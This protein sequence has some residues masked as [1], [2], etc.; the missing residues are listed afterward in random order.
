VTVVGVFALFIAQLLLS[1]VIS[2]GAY[3]ISSL[4]SQ[5]RQLDREVQALSEQIDLL[6][7]PQSLATKAESLGMVLSATAPAFVRLA[8][9]A[10]IGQGS[11]GAVGNALLGSTG[12]L[13]PNS[14]LDTMTTESA[15]VLGA[16]G[17]SAAPAGA[18]DMAPAS[19]A[20]VSTL[21]SLPSPVTR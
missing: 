21:D 12:S 4:N 15:Q 16:T 2:D 1:I 6:S 8:D 3:T 20:V 11:G 5:Q 13:V 10:V 14:L 18:P 19:S 17:P 7:S 9:G